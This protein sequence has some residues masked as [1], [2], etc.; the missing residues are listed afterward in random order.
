MLSTALLAQAS[1]G[2]ARRRPDARANSRSRGRHRCGEEVLSAG[3]PSSSAGRARTASRFLYT[4][5]AYQR[6]LDLTAKQDPVVL[7]L[8]ERAL[9]SLPVS[10][11]STPIP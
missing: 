7:V 11:P 6:A 4:G 8:R 9:A 2:F 5:D 10:L 1:S 3:W